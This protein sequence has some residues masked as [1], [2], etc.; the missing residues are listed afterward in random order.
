MMHIGQVLNVVYDE[1]LG[2]RPASGS[3]KP[4]HVA[5][6]LIRAIQGCY[7]Q[8]DMLGR[9]LIHYKAGKVPNPERSY[10]AL[11]R[12]APARFGHLA[13]S[14]EIFE[15]TRRYAFGLLN[16]DK[17]A[18]PS[19]EKSSFSLTSGRMVTRDGMDN[20]LGMF[21]ANLLRANDGPS[22]LAE[23]LKAAANPVGPCDPVTALV[24]PLIAA[25][26][27]KEFPSKKTAALDKKHNREFVSAV[28][29]A[30][31]CLAEHEKAQGN[32][33]RTLQRA[34]HFA[35]LVTHSHAQAVVGGARN[36]RR[37]PLLLVASGGKQEA[38]AIASERS[39]ERMHV[40]FEAWLGERLA[41]RI[42]KEKPL[43]DGA[44]PLPSDTT[45][46]RTIKAALRRIADASKDHEEPTAEMVDA[47]YQM[48]MNKLKQLGADDPARVL[49]HAL[50]QIYGHEYSSGG[51]RSFLTSLGRRAG[52]LY[53]HFQGRSRE[54]RV[55]PSVAMLDA[56]TRACVE[57]GTV[58]TLEQFLERLWVRFGLIVGGRRSQD[59]DDVA[60][61][62][63]AQIPVEV[64][65]MISN[66]ESLVDD[67][68]LLG[69]ARRYPDGVTFIGDGYAA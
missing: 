17:A 66:T 4:V 59:W 57:P 51:P 44:A 65:D 3:V 9:F 58:I 25:G 8:A 68:V 14:K 43:V 16:A 28:G 23:I 18:F 45:D 42:R 31:A 15:R 48:Y 62:N 5:N 50:V 49:G 35:C 7:F 27:P 6:G 21:A 60:Y 13:T 39:L 26:E 34:T 41:E 69:L 61:L 56:I 47:R 11:T 22:P 32:R 36:A 30:A 37:P 2:W 53:P 20:G 12:E 38:A 1:D 10:E 24:W 33:I 40:E 63:D 54:K 29:V 19:T 52:L 67:L 64:D 55:R 46:G